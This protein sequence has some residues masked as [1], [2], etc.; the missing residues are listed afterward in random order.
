MTDHV[1]AHRHPLRGA[2]LLASVA[3]LATGAVVLVAGS[4]RSTNTTAGPPIA[5]A[6]VVRADLTAL[7]PVQGALTYQGDIALT[8]ERAGVAFTWLPVPGQVLSRGQRVAAVDDQ[9]TF[10]FYGRVPEWRSLVEGVSEG[11]DVAELNANL[12]AL[13]FGRASELGD[14]LDAYG[15]GTAVA[16]ERWQAAVGLPVTGGVPLGTIIYAPKSVRVVSLAVHLGS[17]S[18]PGAP[19]LVV[20][21]PTPQVSVP[22][23]VAQ[24]NLIRVGQSV[25]V[26]MP[27]GYTTVPGTVATIA[28]VATVSQGQPTVA[29][30]IRLRH[31][32][33]LG[34]SLDQAPVTVAI[35]AGT[36][37]NALAVPVNALL[38]LAGGGYAVDVREPHGTRLV[39]VHTGLFAGGKVQ[40]QGQLST[41]SEVEVPAS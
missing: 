30:T 37:R 12:L 20:G 26:T 16:V 40:V 19:L 34:V 29:V 1:G 13:G 6:P 7:V 31:R 41:S 11:P 2:V 10:L 18:Q 27:D 33:R 24:E 32:P 21:S 25:T 14:D 5:W 3:I 36:V 9:P 22:L 15:W 39:A 38:A 8:G 17:P 23:P 35:V 4:R 28:P